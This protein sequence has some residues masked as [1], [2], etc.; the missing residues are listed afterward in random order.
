MG[1]QHKTR[2]R[3]KIDR[4]SLSPHEALENKKEASQKYRL[5][6]KEAGWAEALARKVERKGKRMLAAKRC[7]TCWH[8]LSGKT[9]ICSKIEVLPF[10]SHIEFFPVSL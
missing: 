2:R 5:L 1:S 4:L 8:S 7:P 6:A 9:C 3:R 10:S